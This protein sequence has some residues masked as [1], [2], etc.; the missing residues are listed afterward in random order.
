MTGK[1]K[2]IAAG[3]IG[4]D[5]GKHCMLYASSAADDQKIQIT[6]QKL[7]V[8]KMHPIQSIGYGAAYPAYSLNPPL[9]A[10]R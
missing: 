10:M 2:S 1:V 5:T 8:T 4:L 6:G 3:W 9:V 7:K